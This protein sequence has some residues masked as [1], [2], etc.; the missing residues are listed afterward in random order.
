MGIHS[1]NEVW[2][3]T[4]GGGYPPPPS[5]LQH[6]LEMDFSAFRYGD[7]CFRATG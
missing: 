3:L 6:R 5:C 1:V 2:D 7:P 4:E